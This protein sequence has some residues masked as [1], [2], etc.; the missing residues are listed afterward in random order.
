[1][2][3][4]LNQEADR[5]LVDATQQLSPEERSNAFLTHCRLVMEL[6]EIGRELEARTGRPQS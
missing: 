6:Y 4:K 1:V 3:S 2:K 5:R